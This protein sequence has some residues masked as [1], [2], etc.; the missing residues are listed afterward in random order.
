MIMRL[1]IFS[2]VA[3]ASAYTIFFK[4]SH[5]KK[6]GLVNSRDLG[7]HTIRNDLSTYLK[8]LGSNDFKLFCSGVLVL[9]LVETTCVV[10]FSNQCFPVTL[11]SYSKKCK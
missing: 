8:M 2:L 7:H 11:N 3:G 1:I 10:L 5:R 4:K 6:S 9:R